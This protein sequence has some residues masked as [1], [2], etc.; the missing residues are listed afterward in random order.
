MTHLSLRRFGTPNA[1][2]IGPYEHRCEAQLQLMHTDSA[3]QDSAPLRSDKLDTPAH[4]QTLTRSIWTNL[5]PTWVLSSSL[6][7]QRH[8]D[9]L[10]RQGLPRLQVHPF[11]FWYKATI[12]T[13]RAACDWPDTGL[14]RLNVHPIS[15]RPAW[16][17]RPSTA[18][19]ICS[20][21]NQR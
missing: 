8:R 4:D 5:G 2:H 12:E 7:P 6:L 19:R 9:T 21:R 11:P 18:F 20:R 16:P 3:K 14:I 1:I 13:V 17:G 15:F 10:D